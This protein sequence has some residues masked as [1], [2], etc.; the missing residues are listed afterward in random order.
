MLQ[1]TFSDVGLSLR[2]VSSGLSMRTRSEVPH[3]Y[4]LHAGMMFSFSTASEAS[5]AAA[6]LIPRFRRG[7]S[8]PL[9]LRKRRSP[10]PLRKR[11]SPSPRARSPPIRR[12][13]SP[14]AAAQRSASRAAS[15]NRAGRL[16]L[17]DYAT[18]TLW[19]GQVS[20]L[21]LFFVTR[22]ARLSSGE[23]SRSACRCL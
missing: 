11:R 8:P 10:S 21:D 13:N 22:L 5:A 2:G 16:Q 20:F 17:P 23:A 14:V 1:C 12:R 6:V 9:L 4:R 3:S 18:S 15:P 19:L 7:S